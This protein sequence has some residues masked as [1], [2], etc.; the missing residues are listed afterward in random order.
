MQALR[1]TV[2]IVAL[3]LAGA[4]ATAA[5]EPVYTS[6]F[7]NNAVGGHDVVAYFDDGRPVK[8]SKKH[9]TN[10]NG[11]RWLFASAKNLAAFE[12][13]PERY[14]PQYGG[15]CAWA[16][17]QGYTAKGNPDNWKIVD[18]KLYLNYDA[19]VQKTWESDIP[20]FIRDANTNW[21]KLLE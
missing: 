5:V 9:S 11:A 16:V 6:L 12:A 18:G 21:P 17:S 13:E 1:N 20:G 10:W 19:N 15:Y 8:G 3:I 2:A 7:S 4:G 14:A